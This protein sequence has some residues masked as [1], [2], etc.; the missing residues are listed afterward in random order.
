LRRSRRP[1]QFVRG[2][3]QKATARGW[4]WGCKGGWARRTM[5][6]SNFSTSRVLVAARKRLFDGYE[7]VMIGVM[8]ASTIT[9]W[10]VH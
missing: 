10:F 9:F 7:L 3:A 6:T 1:A 4:H 5:T 2:S 8:I